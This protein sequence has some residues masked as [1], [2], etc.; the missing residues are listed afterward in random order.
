[1]KSI[2]TI[3]F[4]VSS[5]LAYANPVPEFP[6]I[7]LT[8]RIEKQV[9]PD[10]VKIRFGLVAYSPASSESLENL[11]TAGKSVIKL[12][13]KYE[14]PLSL[15]ESTQI[16]K[17][18]KRA[19]KD[20][21]YNLDVLGYETAQSFNLK[22]GDLEKYPPLMNELIAIDGVSGIEAFF[23]SSNEERYKAD[24]I[25]E[26]SAKARQKADTLAKAQSKSVKGVYGIT[27]EGNFGE[28]YAVFT[29]QYEPRIHANL[30]SPSSYGMDLTMMVPEYIEVKQRMTVIYQL[31]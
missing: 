27:T 18:A 2:I 28:A 24:M 4:L 12:L 23:E 16:D 15:L 11:R 25:Q 21:V 7:I 1:M 31:K 10:V 19:R 20:G 30:A 14:I 26:L 3:L 6:F 5:V 9:E 29:L 17:R 8:E 22:L 13:N